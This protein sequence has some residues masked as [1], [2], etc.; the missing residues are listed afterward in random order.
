ME[1]CRY[2]PAAK[3]L[4]PAWTYFFLIS[5]ES[6]LQE[7]VTSPTIARKNPSRIKRF[8]GRERQL[9]EPRADRALMLCGKVSEAPEETHKRQTS[10]HGEKGERLRSGDGYV[11]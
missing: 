1:A 3:Y 6:R 4:F 7:I 10:R 11:S 8:L 9:G 5:L 2:L